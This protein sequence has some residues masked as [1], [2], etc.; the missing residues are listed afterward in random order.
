VAIK[1]LEKFEIFPFS[2]VESKKIH[3]TFESTKL[4]KKKPFFPWMITTLAITKNSWKKHCLKQLCPSWVT[5]HTH[6]NF[7]LI[8]V[9]G[10]IGIRT[11]YGKGV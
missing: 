6:K 3:Q 7:S 1:F 5:Y 9:A 11:P 8:P 2:S 4:E 10:G